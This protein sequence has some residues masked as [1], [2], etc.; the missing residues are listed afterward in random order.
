[1][2]FVDLFA[3]LGGFHVGLSELGHACVLACEKDSELRRYYKLNFGVQP[4][5]DIR[6]LNQ[7]DVPAHDILCAGFPCQPFSKAGEQ[8]GLA[9]EKDGDLF[10]RIMQIAEWRRPSY[11]MLENVA[12][13]QKHDKGKTFLKMQKMLAGLPGEY[14]VDSKVLSPHKFGIPQ[15]RERLFIVAASKKIGGLQ[16]FKWPKPGGEKPSIYSVLD[17]DTADAKQIPEHYSACIDVWQEFLDRFPKD[18]QLPSFPIWSMEFG[19]TYPFEDK[20]PRNQPWHLARSRGN[21]GIKL[22]SVPAHQRPDHLPSYARGFPQ[23][24][25][26]K[27]QFIRQNRALYARNRKWI[28]D[29]LPKILDFPSSL[30]KLEWNCKGEIR[31]LEEHVLQFR[32]SGI[33]VKRATTAPAL[34]A[35]TTTQVPIIGRDRRYMTVNECSRLQGMGDLVLPEVPTRAYRALGNAVN[36]DLVRLIAEKLIGPAKLNRSAA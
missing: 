32:A 34:I 2:Q 17:E 20:S 29:W 10:N 12:N 6:A 31:K 36:A 22:G 11:I 9:C 26:W 28:D 25:A 8:L 35:M 7:A 27:K 33:R 15:V 14:D 19:A 5:E 16:R 18:E 3:G 4:T 30:Q 1:M 24:P 21:H 23:F 13:L